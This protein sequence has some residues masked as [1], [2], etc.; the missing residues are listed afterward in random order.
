MGLDTEMLDTGS[1][2]ISFNILNRFTGKVQFT[3]EI[4]CAPDASESVKMGLAVRLA[5]KSR[6]DLSCTYL[7]G[8]DLRSADIRSA[9]LSCA[10]LGDQWIIQ[11]LTRSDGYMFFLQKLNDDK[12]P[13]VKAGCRY[14]TLSGAHAH[15][16]GTRK[17]T[18]LFNET[19]I[20]VRCMVDIAHARGFMKD[21]K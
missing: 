3:A 4:D 10:N 13:I 1:K 21:G 18:P 7:R 11:G 14:L 5:I 9:D 20:I 19:R 6:A 2:L 15:W 8:A 17:G 12:E 16:E